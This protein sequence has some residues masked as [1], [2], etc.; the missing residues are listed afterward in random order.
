MFVCVCVCLFLSHSVFHRF[1]TSILYI[2]V[3]T[4]LSL[5]LQ[6]KGAPWRAHTHS[7]T[8]SF[9]HVIHPNDSI[10]TLHT[11]VLFYPEKTCS[12]FA[13]NNSGNPAWLYTKND[14][15]KNLLK[16]WPLFGEK[17]TDL[18]VCCLCCIPRYTILHIICVV[19]WTYCTRY[20][21]I[22]NIH[23]SVTFTS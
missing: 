13:I 21:S 7:H 5:L 8:D 15:W 2:L 18:F 10:F 17:I 11:Q 6:K 22:T 23:S 9:F 19:S 1:C 12:K 4:I 20:T 3:Y 14:K 16:N